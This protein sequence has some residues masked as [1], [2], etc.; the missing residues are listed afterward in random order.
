MNL[1]TLLKT[2][3]SILFAA[4]YVGSLYVFRGAL[5]KSRNDIEVIR[6]RMIAVLACCFVSFLITCILC[7]TNSLPS[8]LGLHF[9]VFKHV[10]ATIVSVLLNSLLFAA[11][12]IHLLMEY[13][14]LNYTAPFTFDLQIGNGLQDAY[15]SIYQS[16]SF[17]TR[18]PKYLIFGNIPDY[19]LQNLMNFRG[20]IIGPATEEFVFRSCAYAVSHFA[21]GLSPAETITST[22]LIFGL[23]HCHHVVEHVMHGKLTL[24]QATI[25]VAVQ[26]T[27]TSIFAAYNGYLFIRTGSLW[28]SV[29]LHS[30]CNFLELPDFPGMVSHQHKIMFITLLVSGLSLFLL[31]APLLTNQSLFHSIY[32]V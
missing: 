5:R 17:A 10:L 14:Y 30:Y 28:A 23:A 9:N 12:I 16:W 26:F 29:I 1:V 13:G 21:V 11:P 31:G 2:T 6:R 25:N 24:A 7:G 19:E 18:L 3:P 4:I 22:S 15:N 8:K 20:I 32:Y 27:Y